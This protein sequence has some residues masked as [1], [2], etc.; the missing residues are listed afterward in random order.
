MCAGAIPR[1]SKCVSQRR[2]YYFL[3]VSVL[4]S[5]PHLY[6]PNVRLPREHDDGVLLYEILLYA[7]AIS[8]T[9]STTQLE[10]L[11]NEAIV[12][13]VEFRSKSKIL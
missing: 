3:Q 9:F 7:T 4:R 12:F 8:E 1:A 11:E 5:P 10:G 6:A 13:F 2:F